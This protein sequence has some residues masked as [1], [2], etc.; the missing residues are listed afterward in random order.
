MPTPNPEPRFRQSDYDSR[1]SE[2]SGIFGLKRGVLR[3]ILEGTFFI[4]NVGSGKNVDRDSG[5]NRMSALPSNFLHA[6]LRSAFR[7]ITESLLQALDEATVK[8]GTVWVLL[9]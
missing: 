9:L 4:A 8:V 1:L 2:I 5:A 3:W 6:A 7:Q